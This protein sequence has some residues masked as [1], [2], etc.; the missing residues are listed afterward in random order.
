M[1][2]IRKGFTLSVAF[3]FC[4]VFCLAQTP[5]QLTISIKDTVRTLSDLTVSVEVSR[6]DGK[7]FSFPGLITLGSTVDTKSLM[8]YV[9]EKYDGDQY[10]PFSC[11][12]KV[13]ENQ[14]WRKQSESRMGTFINFS[15]SGILD[16][17][18]CITPGSYRLKVYYDARRK[19]DAVS[20]MEGSLQSEWRYFVLTKSVE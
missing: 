18:A 1:R 2:T 20:T 17:V 5:D 8:T 6:I 11:A 3:L 10:Q 13:K 19:K 15:V 14:Q 12:W 9:L 7:E 4:A 16:E